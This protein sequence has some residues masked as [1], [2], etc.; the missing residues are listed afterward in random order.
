MLLPGGRGRDSAAFVN[1]RSQAYRDSQQ[2]L[3]SIKSTQKICPRAVAGE[4]SARLVRRLTS[5]GMFAEVV[6][7]SAAAFECRHRNR[8]GESGCGYI[9]VSRTRGSCVGSGSSLVRSLV[10][11]PG[12]TASRGVDLAAI[13]GKG[14]L[15]SFRGFGAGIVATRRRP[16]ISQV[17]GCQGAAAS[18][19]KAVRSCSPVSSVPSR[20]KAGWTAGSTSTMGK[21]GLATKT[22]QT[23]TSAR[24]STGCWYVHDDQVAADRVRNNRLLRPGGR[25]VTGQK[26]C[27]RR[28]VLVQLDPPPSASRRRSP[29]AESSARRSPAGDR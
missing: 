24:S 22:L 14:R 8:S 18:P 7:P 3:A 27:D 4:R 12:I 9:M 21:S 2:G 11:G 17:G 29:E 16:S 28:L 6:G 13:G 19:S 15:F 23:G 1:R 25:M 10:Q 26:A 5:A 20:P